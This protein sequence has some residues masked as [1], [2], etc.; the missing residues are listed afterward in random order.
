M[1]PKTAS[2]DLE[3]QPPVTQNIT[4]FTSFYPKAFAQPSHNKVPLSLVPVEN[5]CSM[6]P[7]FS[8]SLL[9]APV[10]FVEASVVDHEE[11][12]IDTAMAS[13]LGLQACY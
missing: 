1:V 7:P 2:L 4:Y 12:L 13:C 9:P 11:G 5:L 8:H 10:T 6:I 3:A